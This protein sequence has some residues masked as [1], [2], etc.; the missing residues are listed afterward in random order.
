MKIERSVIHRGYDRQSCWVHC[1]PGYLPGSPRSAVVTMQKLRLT[2]MD[3]FSNLYE[4]RSDDDGRTWT[5]PVAHTDTLGR[6]VIDAA[7]GEEENICDFTPAW[8]AQTGTLLGTGHTVRY[9][10]DN[11]YAT[12]TPRDTAYSVY[13]PK[14][15]TWARW[16]SLELP[17]ELFFNEGAGCTQR[18]DLPNGD[19]L[20]PTYVGIM[21]TSTTLYDM[22]C[23]STVLRCRFDGQALHY[24]EHG[25]EITMKEGAG[26]SEPS[27]TCFA[28]RYYLTLRNDISGHVCVS[29]DGLHYDSPRPWL[30]DDGSNLG[31]YW[32]QQHWIT[33]ADALYLVY[34]RRGAN[35]DHVF[36]HR[37]P[38]FI[39]QVDTAKLCIIRETEQVLVPERGARLGNF[40]I[41]RISDTE[42]WVTVS[43][44]MQTTNPNPHNSTVCERYGSDNSIYFVK[45]RFD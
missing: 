27:M 33:S 14:Q 1:R 4:M 24:V 17:G 13:D 29:E 20:L 32:T 35:N 6:I 28:G 22:Q 45:V 39:A 37:A 36:C 40:G 9:R 31:N 8:H 11:I 21:N 7:L 10:R 42:S 5:G 44:W 25:S 26:F 41:A 19:I 43:E 18:Y 3:V 30:F 38:L 12:D 2:G 15:R 23:M 34:T 16:K